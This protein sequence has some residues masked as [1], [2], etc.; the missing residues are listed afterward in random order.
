MSLT[1]RKEFVNGK[2]TW[3]RPHYTKLCTHTLPGGKT[4]RVKAGTQ[5]IDRFWGH[6]RAYLKHAPRLVGSAALR[7]KIRAAQWTK[8]F[9][10]PPAKCFKT[11]ANRQLHN[12]HGRKNASVVLACIHIHH[13]TALRLTSSGFLL[14]NHSGHHSC[15]WCA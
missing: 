10:L 12:R 4:I 15:I 9:G 11:C 7:R 2:E 1:R 3:V 13:V 5:V 8:T 14:T 6:L